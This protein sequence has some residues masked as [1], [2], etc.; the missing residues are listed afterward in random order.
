MSSW[1]GA[2]L[3]GALA[4]GALL[5]LAWM[6]GI[7]PRR[8]VWQDLTNVRPPSP[9]EQEFIRNQVRRSLVLYLPLLLGAILFGGLLAFNGDPLGL[10]VMVAFGIPPVLALVRGVRV[11]RYLSRLR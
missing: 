6:R 8:L 3:A 9:V 4:V 5:G 1:I 7:S 11:L 2:A 10:A